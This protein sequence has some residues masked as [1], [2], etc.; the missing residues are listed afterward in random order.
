MQ[1]NDTKE[2]LKAMRQTHQPQIE[3][4]REII[5]KNQGTMKSIRQQL[6]G[7]PQTIPG[8]AAA[9]EMDSARLLMFVATMKKYGEVVEDAK[10]GD[11][12]KY[13]LVSDIEVSPSQTSA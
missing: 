6:S 12:F 1:S 13:A 9:L 10:D 4:A 2:I 3:H 11:Y 5:K 8:M 7:G